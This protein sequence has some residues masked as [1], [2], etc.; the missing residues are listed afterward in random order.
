MIM[1]VSN[2]DPGPKNGQFYKVIGVCRIST[3][4]QDGR[5]LDDQASLYREWMTERYGEGFEMSLI[6]GTG[7][8][9]DLTRPEL[10]ELWDRVDKGDVDIVITEDLGRIARRLE[11]SIF[12]EVAEDTATRVVAI[13]DHVD[14]ADANWRMSSMFASL[15]HESYNRDTSHRI[16]RTLRNR[17]TQGD[18]V[19]SLPYGYLKPRAHASDSEC[20]K[21]P[22]AERIYEEVFRRLEEGQSF[23]KVSDWMNQEGVP[24]GTACRTRKWS[25]SLLATVV[26]NPILKGVRQRNRRVTVRINRT[27]KHRTQPAPADMLLERQVLH[28]AFIDADRYDRVIRLLAQRGEKYRRADCVRNDPRAGIPKKQTQFPGQ[29]IR[30]GVCGRLFVW[31]GHGR[32]ERM[33]CNGAREHH[34]WN[35]MTVD[36]RALARAI[37]DEVRKQIEL[38]PDFDNTW[39]QQL[40][41]EATALAGAND[42]RLDELQTQLAGVDRA[43][44]NLIDLVSSGGC[45]IPSV[46]ARLRETERRRTEIVDA[47][48]A[49]NRQRPREVDLPPTE[50]LRRIARESFADL[51]VESREFGELMRKV[52]DDLYVLPFQL[53]GGGHPQPK[54]VFHLNL[55]T[56]LPD[57]D[58][59]VVRQL[60]TLTV[61]C[62]V[63]LASAP[64]YERIREDVVRMRGEGL[65]EKQIAAMLDVT[66][67]AVQH[68]ASLQR[69]LDA[70]GLQ[71]PWIPVLT[72]ETVRKT[73]KRISHARYQFQPLPGFEHPITI[74]QQVEPN[75]TGGNEPS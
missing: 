36:G 73:F 34:C 27:G 63:D 15:R 25:G 39:T 19:Q 74:D 56:L 6:Q 23:A 67:T 44:E 38:L 55:A 45:E 1:S 17:F 14:T 30:C 58:A 65:T 33:M 66:V 9:E 54:C 24:T 49:L 40:Q 13:N 8:G 41:T 10:L 18:V 5:S 61:K 47:L 35:A 60:D 31:G 43:M 3:A 52:V 42:Q 50:E 2:Q 62:V 59:Q 26:R 46:L 75:P 22:E 64:Q 57:L 69:K 7:S 48:A 12:C 72:E 68:A 32:K 37:A 20:S 29:H 21:L 51:A 11:A 28:L 71:S 4:H 70:L 53:I 16:R